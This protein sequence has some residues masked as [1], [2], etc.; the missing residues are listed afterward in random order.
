[1]QEQ[2]E[3]R[4]ATVRLLHNPFDKDYTM[5][6][7]WEEEERKNK[8]ATGWTERSRTK[9]RSIKKPSERRKGKHHST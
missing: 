7:E 1:M 3:E 8:K 9:K 6:E 5:Q 4:Q 2:H